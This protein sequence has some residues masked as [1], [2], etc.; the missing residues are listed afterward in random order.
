MLGCFF[1][2]SD[3]YNYCH[4]VLPL[5]LMVRH[6]NYQAMDPSN[7]QC[8]FIILS[9]SGPLRSS[10]L[11][12]GLASQVSFPEGT[13]ARWEHLPQL[14]HSR[15]VESRAH[16]E[17]AQKSLWITISLLLIEAASWASYKARLLPGPVGHVLSLYPLLP[18]MMWNL[19]LRIM[20]SYCREGPFTWDRVALPLLPCRRWSTSYLSKAQI[21]LRAS[22]FACAKSP[23][24]S[25]I[26]PAGGMFTVHTVTPSGWISPF[27]ME[28]E[29]LHPTW[30]CASSR[31]QTD[32]METVLRGVGESLSICLLGDWKEHVLLHPTFGTSIKSLLPLS[33]LFA[34]WIVFFIVIDCLRQVPH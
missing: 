24:S 26:H 4:N 19:G 32:V 8:L 15:F 28:P 21:I 11:W 9:I 29:S 33:F 27:P 12:A 25:L 6:D 22:G 31:P 17:I 10:S 23:R 1:K 18:G 2:S 3:F 20:P 34:S 13:K 5:D 30:S 7:D 14:K 16:S